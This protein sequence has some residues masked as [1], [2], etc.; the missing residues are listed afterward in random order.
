VSKKGIRDAE[1]VEVGGFF[2]NPT[3]NRRE[4]GDGKKRKEEKNR[5]SRRNIPERKLTIPDL[6]PVVIPVV[7]T[8]K[9]EAAPPQEEKAMEKNTTNQNA[10]NTPNRTQQVFDICHCCGK[11]SKSPER[12]LTNGKKIKY[13]VCIADDRCY[14]VYADGAA[15]EFI[16]HRTAIEF[17]TK[18]AWVLN[19]TQL[20]IARM[21][22]E[23]V[24]INKKRSPEQIR[25]V[26][27]ARIEKDEAEAKTKFSPEIVASLSAQYEGQERQELYRQAMRQKNHIDEA[28]AFAD[29][30]KKLIADKAAEAATPAPA[31]EAAAP[32]AS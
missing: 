27:K 10:Q 14:K 22:Q 13:L 2:K 16:A 23:L 12:T 30:V 29:E 7:A 4:R 5:H 28:K 20:R 31:E 15:K 18:E 9:I 3:S 8:K 11:R 32:V 19:Q 26:A 25:A 1:D 17:P 24:E 21:E 6:E